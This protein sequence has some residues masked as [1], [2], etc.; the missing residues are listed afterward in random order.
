[1]TRGDRA[2][3]DMETERLRDGGMES[4]KQAQGDEAIHNPETNN[5]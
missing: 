2:K 1:M 3:G 4:V 5:L